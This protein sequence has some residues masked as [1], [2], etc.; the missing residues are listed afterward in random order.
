MTLFRRPSRLVIVALVAVA[1]GAGVYAY[2]AANTVPGS[3]AG[4]GSGAISGYTVS[5]ITYTLNATTPTNLDAVSFTIAPTAATTVNAQLAS[6][7]A[8]YTCAN[9]AGSVT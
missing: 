5:G 7:G 6:G 9:A 2:A 4:A 3:T 8:W 1:I